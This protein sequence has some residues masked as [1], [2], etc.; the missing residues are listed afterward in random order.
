MVVSRILQTGMMNNS[1]CIFD[2]L[3]DESH[4][5]FT[6][7]PFNIG[8]SV[9]LV[10]CYGIICACGLFGNA[11]VIYVILRSSNMKTVTNM[12]I[13][14]LAI[15][16]FIFLISMPL[17]MTTTWL[18]FWLF[19]PAMCKVYNIMYSINLFT[20]IFTLTALSADRYL[21]V[22][23]AVASQRFRTPMNSMLA[24]LGIWAISV[25]VMLPIILYANTVPSFLYK[26][27]LSCTISWPR[28]Q[29]VPPEKAYTWYT[30]M[31]GFAVPVSLV[32]IFYILVIIRIQNLGPANQQK[33][34][35]RRKKSKKVTKM[36]LTVISVYVICWLP[37]WIF[38]VHLTL[39][40]GP[41]KLAHW[42]ILLFNLMTVMTF[43]N[44]MLNPILYAFLS[45]HFRKGFREAFKCKIN[46]SGANKSMIEEQSNFDRIKAKAKIK[47]TNLEM[48]PKTGS[49]S[50]RVLTE[51]SN[52]VSGNGVT[53]ESPVNHLMN[54]E[55]HV[56]DGT[57]YEVKG[58]NSS[59]ENSVLI[60][61]S[62]ETTDF[63]KTLIAEDESD[64]KNSVTYIDKESQ[65]K[66]H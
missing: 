35:E 23:H 58:N 59:D 12:Y 19:G 10:T 66:L 65:T 34:S 5:N 2:N 1:S 51:T 39:K 54:N 56:Y 13:V 14:N 9:S 55:T 40:Q 16:D 57:E 60:N 25:L 36:V 41:E 20:G 28:N 24:I 11:L 7:P 62:V 26:D 64:D 49:L 21:A 18:R 63:K 61:Q 15:S 47:E 53:P 43:A 44:S 42:K 27:K 45:E 32:S 37:Y 48:N 30:F 17:L 4:N 3:T 31:L 6:L 29:I 38:Q 46:A 22:C 33:S 52:C 8:I 50:H